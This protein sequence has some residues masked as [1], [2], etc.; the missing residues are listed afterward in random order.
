MAGFSPDDSKQAQL[1]GNTSRSHAQKERK[2]FRC[3]RCGERCKSK[4]GLRQHLDSSPQHRF[5]VEERR[6]LT[7]RYKQLRDIEQR[8]DLTRC[9]LDVKSR[10]AERLAQLERLY[11]NNT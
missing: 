2:E 1:G 5:S 6:V 7:A 11:A 4:R 10:T 3:L 8:R 9:E